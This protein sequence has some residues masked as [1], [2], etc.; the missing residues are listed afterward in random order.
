LSERIGPLSKDLVVACAIY[1]KKR[2]KASDV[3]NRMR[4]IVDITP[5]E[6]RDMLHSLMYWGIIRTEA[7]GT[8]RFYFISSEAYLMIKE[9][10]ELFWK[11]VVG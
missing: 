6:L 11:K 9:T 8:D 4:G 5:T 3:I 7:E 2:A 1:E 10:Y